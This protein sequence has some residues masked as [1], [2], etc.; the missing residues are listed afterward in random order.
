MTTPCP[1]LDRLQALLDNELPEADQRRCEE[2]LEECRECRRRLEELAGG[3]E[4]MPDTAQPEGSESFPAMRRVMDQLLELEKRAGA[5]CD[6]FQ[7]AWKAGETPW[8]LDYSEK[9]QST[10]PGIQQKLAQQLVMI[11]LQHRWHGSTEP[12]SERCDSSSSAD[13]FDT[14]RPRLE[15]Y[16][17]VMPALGQL[18]E[19]P[20]ELIEHE[21][22]V[23]QH[24]GELPSRPECMDRFSERGDLQ[25]ILNLR[26]R[27]LRQEAWFDASKT[28]AVETTPGASKSLR[29][30][31]P[32]CHSPIE[33]LCD[34]PLADITCS[35]CGSD[36]NL[37]SD[38]AQTRRASTL[39]TVAHFELVEQ[40]GAGGFG[41]VWKARDTELDRVVAV[42]IPRKGQLDPEEAEQF[43]REARAAAQLKHPNIVSVH[44]VGRS[45][46][47]IYIVSDLVRGVT[48]ADWLTGQRFTRREAVELCAKIA[49]ALDHAHQSGIV[50]RDLKPGNIM[51]DADGE[52]HLMDFG[53]AKREAGEI[54]MT[55]DGRIM[56]TPAYM[57]PE[58]ARGEGHH[59]D[60]RSDVY[61]LG[62]ILFQLLTGELPFRGNSRMLIMQILNEEPP[63]PRR[64]NRGISRDLETV[65][66]KCLEKVPARRYASAGEVAE[67]L[68]RF[69][70]GEPV[71]ARPI[72]TFSRR[73]RWCRRNPATAVLSL[74]AVFLLL[75]LA[76]VSTIAYVH[77][78]IALDDAATAQKLQAAEHGTV[79]HQRDLAIGGLYSSLVSEARAI[80]VSR[81]Q[82]YRQKA[83]TLLKRA[84]ELDTPKLDAEDLRQV[85]VACMGDFVGFQPVVWS[86]FPGEPRSVAVHPQ[87]PQIAVAL[88]DGNVEIR[89]AVSGSRVAALKHRRPVALM[90]FS[91]D[92]TKLLCADAS[93]TVT[94]WEAN[95]GK[96]SKSD[97]VGDLRGLRAMVS[98]RKSAYVVITQ[99]GFLLIRSIDDPSRSH[100]IETRGLYVRDV[101]V[102]SDGKFLAAGCR[103]DDVERLVVWDL[104]TGERL[105]D[106]ELVLGRVYDLAF[107]DAAAS[108]AAGCENGYY[109]TDVPTFAQ[110]GA[111]RCSTAE[112]VA[113]SADRLYLAVGCMSKVI[114]LWDVAATRETI[115]LR[116]PDRRRPRSI[117]FGA[118]GT[119][120]ASASS[121]SVRLWRLDAPRERVVLRGHRGGIPGVAFSPDGR[122]LASCGK[123][124]TV[125]LWDT[126]TGELSTT[127]SGF[128]GDV[129]SVAF[130]AD[131]G[132]LATGD[133]AGAIKLWDV[134]SQE[135][136]EVPD[137]QIGPAWR[138][139]FSRD[140]TCFAASAGNGMAIW[141]VK[142]PPPQPTASPQIALELVQ[143]QKGFRCQDVC[144]SP[145]GERL[146]WVDRNTNVRLWDLKRSREI[147]QKLPRL[148]QQGV[149][150]LAFFPNGD[151]LAF[152]GERGTVDV[153]SVSTG[154]RVMTIGRPGQF[155]NNFIALTEDGR[156]LAVEESA[157]TISI[158]DC[159]SR[160]MLVRLPRQRTSVWCFA[161]SPKGNLLAV[162]LN[163]GGL[164][165]WDLE[166]VREQLRGLGLDWEDSPG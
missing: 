132:C 62:V 124:R 129:Q 36:F 24:S 55:V 63:S 84:G 112:N 125:R 53:L 54:T 140:G 164:F 12:A 18:V 31:C 50:H 134:E 79:L 48:L 57:S 87:L 14:A 75:A 149:Q 26:Q 64:L 86:D 44:E 83:W 33:L 7:A 110:R 30:R 49:D 147:S 127:F 104:A 131:G 8:I 61:S 92:G 35:V 99:P 139:A 142:R 73:W 114:R 133:W 80:R 16:I 28:R 3:I 146:A 41:T 22:R 109:V 159:R 10:K 138:L 90:A 155:E 153:W 150:A 100:R 123:D 37:V 19:L 60:R 116:H 27:L 72:G 126:A 88:A 95:E 5:V 81:T 93:R 141:R 111:M 158:W 15:D 154:R 103:R 101:S 46:D 34:A 21:F 94:T 43:L 29:I 105:H 1:H 32:H 135:M 162:G 89:D 77:T 163:D 121:S 78:R 2:H 96:Y 56:G 58:Q 67:D 71:G 137:C 120:L 25:K 122:L 39:A 106:T 152:V 38:A 128:Q 52:P 20:L 47:T 23:R 151:H 117:C 66:L 136:I 82:G 51:L 9:L 91:L 157:G 166:A 74:T 144:I 59:A 69:L 11:D 42:K 17:R 143:R 97:E 156:R 148:L 113:F 4:G 40:L 70:D 102:S 13:C 118:S 161:F 130:S 115:T 85:A 145:D 6:G 119:L 165:L 107:D 65:C 68:K 76:V 160:K 98:N 108:L 45:E